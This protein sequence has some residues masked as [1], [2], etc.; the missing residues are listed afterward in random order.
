MD[1]AE[2]RRVVAEA[3]VGRLA[4][5]DPDGRPHLVPV[6]FVVDGDTVYTAV[7]RKPKRSLRLRRLANVRRDPR[8]TLLVDHYD[9]D[10]T[11]LWW[12]RLRGRGRV[13]DRG[14]ERELAM[15][16]LR[17][18]YPQYREAPPPGPVLALEVDEWRGWSAS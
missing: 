5:L 1:S 6:V 8:A 7:D 14:V 3:R 15:H 17:D 4:T 9:E 2:L 11:K 12:V 13:V 16:L 10:W 18:K